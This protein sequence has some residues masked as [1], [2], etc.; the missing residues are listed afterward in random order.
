MLTNKQVLSIAEGIL[1]LDDF[2]LATLQDTKGTDWLEAFKSD[3]SDD[4]CKII[5]LMM[6]TEETYNDLSIDD[7]KIYDTYERDDALKEYAENYLYE[8]ILPDIPHHLQYYFDEESWKE[9]FIEDTSAAD[10]L[11]CGGYEYEIQ[12]FDEIYYIYRV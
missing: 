8:I 5:T 6:H 10:A 9:D 12:L 11:S 7:Y 1:Y 4:D 2:K 3:L